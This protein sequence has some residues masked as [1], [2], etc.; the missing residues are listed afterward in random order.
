[1]CSNYSNQEI[2]ERLRDHNI[3]TWHISSNTVELYTT[4]SNDE[5]KERYNLHC[6]AIIKLKDLLNLEDVKD[7]SLIR[8][9][10]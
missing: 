9:V 8:F 5:L 7:Y 2:A 1:M 3:D 6:N 4:K 10:N